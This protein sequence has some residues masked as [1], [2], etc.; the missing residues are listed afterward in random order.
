MLQIRAEDGHEITLD[1]AIEEVSTVVNNFFFNLKLRMYSF[2]GLLM[3]NCLIICFFIIC[4]LFGYIY[5][6][7]Q[8]ERRKPHLSKGDH[9]L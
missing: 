2:N 7:N 3:G 9:E 5:I 4:W 8:K 6:V 1:E